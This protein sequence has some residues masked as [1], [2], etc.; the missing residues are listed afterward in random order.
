MKRYLL[1]ITVLAFLLLSCS[2]TKQ[3]NLLEIPIDIDQNNSLALSEIAEEI[4]VIELELTDKSTLKMDDIAGNLL[5]YDDFIVVLNDYGREI[6]LFDNH[7][8]F[9]RQIG[10]RGQGPGEFTRVHSI[11]ADIQNEKIFVASFKKIICY[12]LK[13][14]LINDYYLSQLEPASSKY[15]SYLN[16][17]LI[18]ICDYLQE[19]DNN[20]TFNHSVLYKLNNDLQIKDSIDIGKAYQ[21]N[22]TVYS[23]FYKDFITKNGDKTYLYYSELG[24]MSLLSDTLYSI[25]DT[26]LIPELKLQ[27]KDEKA[28]ITN[29]DKIFYIEN[30]YRNSRYIFSIY[31]YNSRYFQFCYDTKT[32]KGYNIQ[33]YTDDIHQF[34]DEIMIHPIPSDTE[35]FYYLHTNMKPDDLEEP[36]PTLYIG[37][38]KK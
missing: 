2:N 16:D 23:H 5:I 18:L 14:N 13:G 25:K 32:G 37:K 29:P 36:N 31:I 3:G 26:Y 7:G 8:K 35:M 21:N 24:P 33:G 34:K 27:F 11:T 10:S 1:C 20:G 28:F 19:E 12:D 9:I 15:L 22:M 17:E 38:L 4:K 30:I 6:I